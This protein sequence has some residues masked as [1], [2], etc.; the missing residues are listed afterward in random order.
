MA[1]DGGGAQSG[2]ATPPAPTRRFSR[3]LLALLVVAI[4]AVLLVVPTFIRPP[5]KVGAPSG[6]QVLY[7]KTSGPCAGA[8]IIYV[9]TVV[10]SPRIPVNMSRPNASDWTDYPV[11]VD[12]S[13][14]SQDSCNLYG[15][16]VGL[17]HVLARLT[18]EDDTQPLNV[19]NQWIG[20]RWIDKEFTP[21]P[22]NEDWYVPNG[23]DPGRAT[24]F[25]WIEVEW[26]PAGANRLNAT[27]QNTVL[28][29]AAQAHLGDRLRFQVALD[30][31]ISETLCAGGC[32]S[33]GSDEHVTLDR[34]VDAV[35][36]PA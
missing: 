3:R 35:V 11:Y 22:W 9:P 4:L 6:D 18:V 19:S 16:H 30:L 2:A 34:S 1:V 31:T 24:T 23:T 27:F 21:Y 25:G 12:V 14:P 10:A 20:G 36:V 8:S 17:R 13:A 26:S 7:T 28:T 15:D 32:W 33:P 29:M 5:S